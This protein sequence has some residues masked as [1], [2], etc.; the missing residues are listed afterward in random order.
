M[1]SPACQKIETFHILD[2]DDPFTIDYDHSRVLRRSPITDLYVGRSI[3][4]TTIS[5]S[6]GC[7]ASNDWKP[8]FKTMTFGP[9]VT[10]IVDGALNAC[11]NLES[12]TFQSY[13]VPF[14]NL[15]NVTPTLYVPASAKSDYEAK[16]S[17]TV[18]EYL[19]TGATGWTTG[20]VSYDATL[21]DS[22]AAYVVEDV[23]SDAVVLHKIEDGVIPA[24]KGIL[25]NAAEGQYNLEPTSAS[26][27]ILGSKLFVAAD[28]EYSISDGEK[29]SK[30]FYMLTETDEN[31][32]GFEQ[33]EGTQ[34]PRGMGY[35]KLDKSSTY[36][37]VLEL[38]FSD[39]KTT[40]I[41]GIWTISDV[42]GNGAS[43]NDASGN[44]AIHLRRSHLRPPG[45]PREPD[46]EGQHLYHQWQESHRQ[47]KNKESKLK[48]IGE[49][50]KE[51]TA[52]SVRVMTL[53]IENLMLE[54][55]QG[56]GTETVKGVEGTSDLEPTVGGGEP[57][58]DPVDLLSNRW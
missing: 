52:P 39:G 10:S 29:D 37:N 11:T 25:F 5:D 12:V 2:G 38:S 49:M 4:S 9:K 57:V 56:G 31:A 34:I 36:N 3:T 26:H 54:G 53:E 30:V 46:A 51:Y 19:A 45:A 58:D 20:A 44:D 27:E 43:V 22:T 28:A 48:I 14:N 35:L 7:F 55:S 41:S 47:I 17:G 33:Y 32:V 24:G 1:F 8:S 15:G 13:N 6:Q 16:Y 23:T 18:R 42:S 21:P 40:G 50:K